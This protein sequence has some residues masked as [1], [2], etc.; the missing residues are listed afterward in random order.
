MAV[1]VSISVN[2]TLIRQ[3]VLSRNSLHPESEKNSVTDPLGFRAFAS[4]R[5]TPF[6]ATLAFLM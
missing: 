2:S 4:D 3:D 6:R 1:S 5:N